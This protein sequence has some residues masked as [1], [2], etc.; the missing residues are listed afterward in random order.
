MMNRILHHFQSYN[1][2]RS[3]TFGTRREV[4]FFHMDITIK[5]CLCHASSMNAAN[6]ELHQL[7]SF[8]FTSNQS[9][10]DHPIT[11]H[12]QLYYLL[13]ATHHIYRVDELDLNI[14]AERVVR[15]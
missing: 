14:V 9:W 8:L 1:P 3:S 15:E 13:L 7:F 6:E 4:Q 2:H 10:T 5:T 12:L 11:Y